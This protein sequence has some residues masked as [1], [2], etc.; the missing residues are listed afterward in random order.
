MTPVLPA[1]SGGVPDALQDKFPTAE[2]HR[3]GNWGGFEKEYCCLLTVSPQNPLFTKIG[4]AFVEEVE[5]AYG[6]NHVYSCDT[7]NENRPGAGTG[8]T[9]LEYLASSSKVRLL[10]NA[11]HSR[12][13]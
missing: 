3:H 11:V 1:F 8:K 4:K 9:D 2:F 5:K 13:Q 10:L 7:F 6:T 12:N